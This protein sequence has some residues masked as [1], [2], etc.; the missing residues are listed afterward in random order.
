[1]NAD[2]T[3]NTSAK[4]LMNKFVTSET[5]LRKRNQRDLK[6]SVLFNLKI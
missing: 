6:E 2:D 1:M 3:E 5:G 4:D